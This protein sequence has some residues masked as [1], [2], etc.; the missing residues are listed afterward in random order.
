M[1]VSPQLLQVCFSVLNIFRF[2]DTLTIWLKFAIA[3]DSHKPAVCV[4]CENLCGPEQYIP[5]C[6]DSEQALDAPCVLCGKTAVW[7]IRCDLEPDTMPP[8]VNSN[9][10]GFFWN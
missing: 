2:C 1:T 3:K 4:K 10:F 6:D 8:E 5:C 7:E 9:D